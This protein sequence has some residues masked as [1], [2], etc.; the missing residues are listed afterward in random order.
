MFD[1]HVTRLTPEI[2]VPNSGLLESHRAGWIPTDTFQL[3]TGGKD[4]AKLVEVTVVLKDPLAV[5]QEPAGVIK[6]TE[7]DQRADIIVCG[8]REFPGARSAGPLAGENGG[9]EV[10]CQLSFIKGPC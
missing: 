6:P 9:I 8:I 7:A 3:C 1:G 4:I 5:S 2:G 10:Q